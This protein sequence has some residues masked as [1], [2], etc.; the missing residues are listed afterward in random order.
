M[1][2]RQQQL[3]ANDYPLDYEDANDADWVQTTEFTHDGSHIFA[4]D[5]EMCLSEQGLVLTRIS[6]VNFDN[7]VIYEEL[8]KP[9][10]PIVDYLT[11]YSGITE[12]KLALGAKKT[13]A[14]VQ[15]DLLKL[16]SRSDILIGHSLQ[17][18]LKVMKLSLIH[19]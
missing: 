7:E 1:Y 19:I 13:L 6:L 8:V 15:K 9:D 5:C 17:N 2:K 3:V 11:R 4:L 18:D 16:I 12:E 10:V 14:E